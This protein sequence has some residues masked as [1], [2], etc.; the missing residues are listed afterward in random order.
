MHKQIGFHYFDTCVFL[1]MRETWLFFKKISMGHS[2]FSAIGGIII[3]IIHCTGNKAK[4]NKGPSLQHKNVFAF[5]SKFLD[6]YPCY[7][8]SSSSY[9]IRLDIVNPKSFFII[10]YSIF[11]YKFFFLKMVRPS[12]RF[13]QLGDFSFIDIAFLMSAVKIKSSFFTR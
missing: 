11:C 9:F 4:I 7:V 10:C 3:K 5:C 12:L 8:R 6:F 2:L 1:T 13:F